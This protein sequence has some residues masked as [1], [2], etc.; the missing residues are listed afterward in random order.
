MILYASISFMLVLSSSNGIQ[1]LNTI[2][3]FEQNLQF[4][5]ENSMACG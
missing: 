3:A 4:E 1:I 2:N 5:T